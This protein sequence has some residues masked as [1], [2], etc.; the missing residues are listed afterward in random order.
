[1]Q[2]MCVVFWI[3]DLFFPL[4]SLKI[5]C[6]AIKNNHRLKSLQNVGE[7]LIPLILL[8]PTGDKSPKL[9]TFRTSSKEFTIIFVI[10]YHCDA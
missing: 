7:S 3:A 9:Q 10:K 5:V 6:L 1:M 8:Y 2:I 4:Y